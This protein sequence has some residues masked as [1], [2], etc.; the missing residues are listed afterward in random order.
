LGILEPSWVRLIHIRAHPWSVGMFRHKYSLV[1]A[2]QQDRCTR[3]PE[4]AYGPRHA[5]RR[6]HKAAER[7]QTG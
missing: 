4:A 2:E 7:E 1:K 6:E 5:G 3:G